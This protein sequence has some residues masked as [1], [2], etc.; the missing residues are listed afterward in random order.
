MTC[1]E[2][3]DPLNSDGHRSRGL[4]MDDDQNISEKSRVVQC[5]KVGR[6]D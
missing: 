2:K 3:N 5:Y 1:R 6:Y 4:M